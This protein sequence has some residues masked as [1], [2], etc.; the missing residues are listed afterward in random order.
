MAM[1]AAR[2][3]KRSVQVSLTRQQ[4]FTFGHRPATVQKVA[5][6]ASADGDMNALYHD[7]VGETSQFEDY[8]EVVV[9]WGGMLYPP[10]NVTLE[11][12]IVPLD[13]YTPLDMR[14]PGGVTGMSCA[15]MCDG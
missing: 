14:A 12:K 8:T 3:L 15:G 11:Y 13:V 5:L 6:G 4:M 7:A 10:E 2:E 1:M 9:N